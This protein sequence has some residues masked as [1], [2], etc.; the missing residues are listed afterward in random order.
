MR[1]FSVFH[2]ARARALLVG[3]VVTALAV[4]IGCGGGGGATSVTDTGSTATNTGSTA[5]NTGS[6]ATNTGSTA[7]N[8]GSTATNTGSTATNTGNGVLP[9]NVILF[10]QNDAS[11]ANYSIQALSPT[12]KTPT[13]IL[14]N[15]PPTINPIV[16]NPAVKNQYIAAVQ[17]NSTA[18]Y[19]IYATTGATATGAKTIASPAFALVYTISVS[20]SGSSIVFTGSDSTGQ[21][22]SL[23]Y[24]PSSG[25]TPTILDSGEAC[26]I[27][28]DNDSIVYSKFVGLNTQLFIYSLSKK[29]LTQMTSDVT[30]HDMPQFSKD[31]TKIVFQKG[32]QHAGGYEDYG[33]AIM[34]VSTKTEI[35]LPNAGQINETG[36][37][38]NGTSGS[39]SFIASDGIPYA[40]ATQTATGAAGSTYSAL[41]SNSGLNPSGSTYWSSSTGRGIARV[42]YG[43]ARGRKRKQ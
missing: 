14:S 37:S 20:N 13:A 38:L 19:G 10:S 18:L 30:D 7:T 24:V 42:S 34:T 33:I 32:Y 23:Y 31:G 36:P 25:G 6:T 22:D 5:T 27:G 3:S 43:V 2:S 40:I 26:Q 29:T 35:D 1:L 4:M 12:A 21:T 8:T 17:A 9:P 41:Y 11:D 16:L 15:I 28:P 39:V